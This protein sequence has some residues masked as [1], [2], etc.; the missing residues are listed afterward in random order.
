[1]SAETPRISYPESPE[2]SAAVI[3]WMSPEE[4]E[5][6]AGYVL[7]T[8]VRAYSAE[9]ER[10]DA[11]QPLPNGTIAAR[12][13]PEDEAGVAK[14]RNN[15]L[16]NVQQYES[17]YWRVTQLGDPRTQDHPVV[18]GF[19]KV[20]PSRA[21]LLQKARMQTPNVY[22]DDVIVDPSVQR[23]HVGTALL[24]AGL[25]FSGFDED[26]LAVLEGY[27][28]MPSTEWY[29][30]LGFVANG[31]V[32][33]HPVRFGEHVLRQTQYETERGL[34]IG[35]VVRNLESRHPWLGNAI[36]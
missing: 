27:D 4:I 6:T 33:S 35:G 26:R 31:G 18:P 8:L 20:T 22:V 3:E 5:A 1:M 2:S 13:R 10:E 17:Q 29:R 36:V 9:F 32:V 7:Q 24:H 11:A 30:M 19:I 14:F 16:T 21:S 28:G 25:K 15:M 23:N 12:Y 34:A